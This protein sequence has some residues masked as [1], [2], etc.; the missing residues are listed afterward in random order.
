MPIDPVT[1]GA[2]V[3]AGSNILA[4]LFNIGGPT[5]YQRRAFDYSARDVNQPLDINS[6][7]AK[8]RELTERS[9]SGFMNRI[10]PGLALKTG[11]ESGNFAG[12]LL[13]E[14]EGRRAGMEFNLLKFLQQLSE[15]RRT[16]ALNR[17]TQLAG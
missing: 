8:Y 17:M 6:L 1:A 4:S 11:T 15:N 9:A 5:E 12:E 2:G 7:L 10:A 13:R 16:G 3:Q 14:G